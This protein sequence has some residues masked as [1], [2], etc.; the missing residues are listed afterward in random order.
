MR[1][2]VVRT[3]QL[4]AHAPSISTHI[5][6]SGISTLVRKISV[7]S[8]TQGGGCGGA[9]CHQGLGLLSGGTLGEGGVEFDGVWESVDKVIPIWNFVGAWLPPS[10]F[11][12]FS[13]FSGK[14]DCWF[15][16]IVAKLAA[17]KPR[18]G[19]PLNWAKAHHAPKTTLAERTQQEAVRSH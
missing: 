6:T 9:D 3:F 7:P 16:A 12:A 13:T 10:L 11:I 18:P 8:R 15:S 5:R 14:R 4:S 1:N 19:L 17:K 2:S